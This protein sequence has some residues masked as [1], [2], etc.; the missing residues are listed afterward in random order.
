MRLWPQ[1]VIKIEA[2]A[3]ATHIVFDRPETKNALDKQ[4]VDALS[5]HLTELAKEPRIL[6]LRGAGGVFVSGADISQIKARRA[7]DA[8]APINARLFAQLENYPA[9]TIAAVS[10]FA[11]G[12]GCE[13]AIACD[14]RV[15]A[16][17]AVF[18][19]PEVAL[20]IMPAAGATYRLAR[21]I[22]LGRAKEMIFTGRRVTADEALAMGL[23]NRIAG[24]PEAAADALAA[25]IAAHSAGAVMRAKASIAAAQLPAVETLMAVDAQAQAVLFESADKEQRMSAFLAARKKK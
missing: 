15:A 17:N 9:P 16:P 1:I 2:R 5:E 18:G 7:A 4:S 22:G 8:R 3:H 24:D 25:E 10:G 13:L 11:L 21:L 14:L 23:V 20:G 6:I 19:Q 12:G